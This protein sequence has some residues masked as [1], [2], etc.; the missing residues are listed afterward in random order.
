MLS[1]YLKAVRKASKTLEKE[2]ELE[3]VRLYQ[4]TGDR[5]AYTRLIEAYLPLVISIANK[6]NSKKILDLEELIQEGNQG[7]LKAVDKYDPTRDARIGTYAWWWIYRHIIKYINQQRSQSTKE[8]Y[9]LE[10]LDYRIDT[11]SGEARP[12]EV[13]EYVKLVDE[14][15]KQLKTDREIVV[16]RE[17]IVLR[18]K[19]A[20]LHEIGQELG[21]S[22]Q[23]V[24]QLATKIEQK[25]ERFIKRKMNN[26]V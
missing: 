9:S 26:Y 4:E 22:K 2:E 20:R 1:T 8:V 12:D 23:R 13:L 6:I 7:L 5:K 10:S 17:R 11:A 21:I 3:L 14:F 18:E 16:F 19:G 15:E 25:F 24:A